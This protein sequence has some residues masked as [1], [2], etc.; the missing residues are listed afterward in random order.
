MHRFVGP[1]LRSD[2]ACNPDKAIVDRGVLVNI[3]GGLVP[4]KNV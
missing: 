4:F 2:Q 1:G 3:P